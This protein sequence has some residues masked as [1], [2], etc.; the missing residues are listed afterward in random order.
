MATRKRVTCINKNDRQ[1][2]HERI[3]HIGGADLGTRW[4]RSLADAIRDIENGY[5]EYYVHVGNHIVDV[6][7]SNKNGSKYLKTENDGDS[8]DNLL[9]LPECP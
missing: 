7:V 8:P 4:K 6:I 1:S 3:T 5:C 9:S 2:P